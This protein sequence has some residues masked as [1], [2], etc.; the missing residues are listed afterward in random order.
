MPDE[1]QSFAVWLTGLPASGK[2]T[3][4]AQLAAA[5]RRQ[6]IRPAVLESDALRPILTPHA[7]YSA[8][9]RD[10]FYA[11]LA[12]IGVLLTRQGI[13]VLFDATA[14]LR[15]YRDAARLAIPAF[16]EVYVDCPLPVCQARDPKGIYRAAAN[17]PGLHA[18]YEPPL[19]P[20]FTVRHGDP[21][22]VARILALLPIGGAPC[23]EKPSPASPRS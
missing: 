7:Q 17:V 4:A 14:N 12:A 16:F 8:A 22:V 9:D 21:D 5:L 15:R 20:E 1:T 19:A 2:S 23:S 18:P 6:G 11:Q 10:S 3:L 13:P